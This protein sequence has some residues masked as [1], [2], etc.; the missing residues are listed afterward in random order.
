MAGAHA[1]GGAFRTQGQAVAIAVVEG[2]H[3]FL[4]DI[5]DFADRASEQLGHL[6]DRHSDLTIAIG[7]QH[8]RHVTLEKLP[9]RTALGQHIVHTADCLDTLCHWDV[10]ARIRTPHCGASG[11]GIAA[12]HQGSR[13]KRATLPLA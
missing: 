13:V 5:G 2:V 11:S 12:R 9:Q 8:G 7:R 10:F 3:L 1:A 4:D 6:E